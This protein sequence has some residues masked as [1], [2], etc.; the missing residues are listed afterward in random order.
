L[1]RNDES[2]VTEKIEAAQ[3]LRAC[4]WRGRAITFSV[5]V[6]L[7]T[8]EDKMFRKICVSLSLVLAVVLLLAYIFVPPK[9]IAISSDQIAQA[10]EENLPYEV[11]SL[12]TSVTVHDATVHLNDG[13]KI[14]LR[15]AFEASGLT[16]EGTGSAHVNSAV[17][18]ENG[19]F[20]LT[21][22]KREHVQ[23]E[24][25]ENS[26]ETVSDVRATFEGILRRETEEANASGDA[27][28][29]ALL[30]RR[31]NYVET[32]LESHALEALDRFLSTFPIYNLKRAGGVLAIAALAI[33]NVDVTHDEIL[34]T[35]SFQTFILKVGGIFSTMLFILASMVSPYFRRRD[36]PA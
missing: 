15:A 11:E 34:V 17:R 3:V 25:S 14:Q 36:K 27:D 23:F 20:Y 4:H 6:L 2:F 24:L 21:D 16:L 30:E 26:T 28:R 22:L 12:V 5:S 19:R 7:A 32:E 8:D 13:G 35:L 31:N 33:D 10:L 1:L 9:I 29:I 18:Y